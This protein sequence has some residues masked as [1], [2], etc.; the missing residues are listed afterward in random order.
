MDDDN[1]DE[2]TVIDYT[3]K[4]FEKKASQQSFVHIAIHEPVTVAPTIKNKGLAHT[5]SFVVPKKR[6]GNNKTVNFQNDLIAPWSND[7]LAETPLHTIRS[8]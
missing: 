7:A 1:E 3:G 4:V 6:V 8:P 5:E 2:T